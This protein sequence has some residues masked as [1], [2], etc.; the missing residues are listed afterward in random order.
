[1]AASSELARSGHRTSLTVP[2][3]RLEAEDLASDPLDQ[4]VQWFSDAEKAGQPE[5][6]AAAL[7]TSMPDGRPSVRF[8]LVRSF[9]P[10]GFVFYTNGRSRK[11]EEMAATGWAA[12]AFRWETTSRQ[13]RI[14]GPVGPIEPAASDAYFAARPRESQLGA[15]A[16]D[17][18]QPL[19]SR[20]D[21]DR[22]FAEVAVRFQGRPA[23][24]PPWWGGFRILPVEM[25]FWQQGEFRLH[26]RFRYRV[27]DGH[28]WVV[29]RLYP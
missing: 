15:W 28:T 29:E 20:A 18:S 6:E 10:D 17:Q 8:V 16:S 1:V 12:L 19:A 24:R 23:P 13:V 25:E 5:P 22:R 26:D 21:L 11:A 14:V 3:M 7:A 27:G 4:F 2:G 9:G